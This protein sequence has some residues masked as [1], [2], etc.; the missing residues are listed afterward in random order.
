[1]KC[2]NKHYSGHR[3]IPV[4]GSGY[5]PVGGGKNEHIA[6]RT[7]ILQKG[8]TAAAW[9]A[10]WS[11]NTDKDQCIKRLIAHLEEWVIRHTMQFLTGYSCFRKY[12]L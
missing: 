4:V 6:G 7:P 8:R 3:E 2:T 11:S 10:E 5:P 12:L 1:M 9:P